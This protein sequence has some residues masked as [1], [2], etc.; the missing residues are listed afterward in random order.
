MPP[1]WRWTPNALARDDAAGESLLLKTVHKRD[2]DTRCLGFGCYTSTQQ[3]GI[4]AMAVIVALVVGLIVWYF[5]ARPD[6]KEIARDLAKVQ[7]Q[8]QQQQ[9]PQQER[10]AGILVQQEVIVAS[11]PRPLSQSNGETPAGSSANSAWQNP[12][13]LPPP[14]AVVSVSSSHRDM[15]QLITGGGLSRSS[16][17]GAADLAQTEGPEI[18]QAAGEP[19]QQQQQAPFPPFPPC[20]PFPPGPPLHH[21]THPAQPLLASKK[22]GASAIP[23]PPPPFE[24]G[25][26]HA[27]SAPAVAQLPPPPANPPLAYPFGP[28]GPIRSLGQLLILP[29][30]ACSTVQ[31]TDQSRSTSSGTNTATINTATDS[32]AEQSEPSQTG[33]HSQ[34]ER[35]HQISDS[36]S[37]PR[38][39]SSSSSSGP[40][41][42]PSNASAVYIPSETSS[43][44][45]NSLEGDN[46][47]EGEGVLDGSVGSED[48]HHWRN[49][50]EDNGG[51]D[52]DAENKRRNA[53]AYRAEGER[54]TRRSDSRGRVPE[55]VYRRQRRE[56]SRSITPDAARLQT[57]LEDRA[58]KPS[59]LAAL[60]P[61]VLGALGIASEGR[62]LER[63]TEKEHTGGQRAENYGLSTL[64]THEGNLRDRRETADGSEDSW[65]PSDETFRAARRHSRHDGHSRESQYNQEQSANKRPRGC[66]RHSRAVEDDDGSSASSFWRFQGS[67]STH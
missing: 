34:H 49:H 8:Q 33:H 53:A 60:A 50:M 21:P 11:Q 52:R 39:P 67:G 4:I 25:Y 1:L 14:N 31:H 17:S 20:L 2:A 13:V 36:S 57:K 62:D 54:Q 12:T 9:Q 28:A 27:L 22:P 24:Y 43:G 63:R 58:K 23:P 30:A 56:T 42:P 3:G 6:L 65:C 37:E 18:Q 47:N 38:A 44:S 10:A 59:R 29:P 7:E 45:S 55:R 15:L 32:V 64:E 48:R 35:M 51:A 61:L 46:E 16:T 5:V 40:N 41:S 26:P 19:Q 66:R